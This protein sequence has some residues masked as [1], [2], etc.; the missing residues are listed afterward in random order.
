MTTQESIPSAVTAAV[1]AMK[2]T[3][4]KAAVPDEDSFI[5][6]ALAERTAAQEE[7]LYVIALTATKGERVYDLRDGNGVIGTYAFPNERTPVAVPYSA[8]IGLVG[9]SGWRVL[10][11]NGNEFKANKQRK[12]DL[13]LKSTQ[14]IAH[15]GELTLEA[16][17]KRA[18]A[19]TAPQDIIKG[20]KG[21]VVAW[22]INYNE[23]YAAA[24]EKAIISGGNRSLEELLREAEGVQINDGLPSASSMQTVEV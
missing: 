10:D 23:E 14:T 6:E 11:E 20:T 24:S 7:L 5:K 18:A 4:I 19:L 15:F 8:A 16:L 9:E 22:L 1:S 3:N 12:S 13:T 21:D 2:A 17:R